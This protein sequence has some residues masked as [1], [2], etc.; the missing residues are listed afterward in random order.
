M[1]LKQITRELAKL[2]DPEQAAVL[3]RF[4]K[5]GPGQY[6]EGD[7]FR[8]IRVPVLRQLVKK[9]ADPPLADAENLLHAGHHEDRLLGLLFLVAGFEKGRPELRRRIYQLYLAN[10]RYINNWDLVDVSAPHI[11]GAHLFNRSRATL[12][13]LARSGVLWERRI[14]IVSTFYFIRRNQFDDTLDIARMLLDDKHDLMH[15]ASGWM[16]REV[17]KRDREAEE[18]F[19]REHCT[20]MPR[21]MLRYA[22]ERFSREE[23]L[24]Y[25][26]GHG[27]APPVNE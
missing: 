13:R 23:R 5:T 4:F 19:L 26:S 3:L 11:V 10:T 24:L 1:M 18:I 22:I 14:A 9:Y 20:R 7:M 15:K 27:A 17:G 12:R 8:G 21:T 16:L 2:A 6:G 25:L